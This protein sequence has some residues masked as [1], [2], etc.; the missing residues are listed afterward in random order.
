MQLVPS[1]LEPF[2]VV[3]SR[4]AS[5]LWPL[6]VIGDLPFPAAAAAVGTSGSLEDSD[7]HRNTDGTGL[8]MTAEGVA[9]HKAARLVIAGLGRTVNCALKPLRAVV[10]VMW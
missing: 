8:P 4:L 9:E 2:L 5:P 7:C 3:R 10:D 6:E 1:Y